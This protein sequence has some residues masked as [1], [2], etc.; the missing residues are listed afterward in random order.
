[1]DA[2]TVHFPVQNTAKGVIGL[3]LEGLLGVGAGNERYSTVR[4]VRLE[5]W[6]KFE[7]RCCPLRAAVRGRA[8]ACVWFG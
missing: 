2:T 3:G 8:G 6:T 4:C 7:A 5:R 1:M